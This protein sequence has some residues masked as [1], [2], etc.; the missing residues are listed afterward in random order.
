MFSFGLIAAVLQGVV[1]LVLLLRAMVW[2][3]VIKTKKAVVRLP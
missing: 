3:K 2:E 1:A